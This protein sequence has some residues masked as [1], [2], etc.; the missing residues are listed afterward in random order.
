L[1]TSSFRPVPEKTSGVQNHF[2]LLWEE[3]EN[4]TW[5]SC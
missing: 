5:K 2:G 3:W 1:A 4:R